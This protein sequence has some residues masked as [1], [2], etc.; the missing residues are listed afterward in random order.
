MKGL[1]HSF[2]LLLSLLFFKGRG[3]GDNEVLFIEISY[4]TIKIVYKNNNQSYKSQDGR[5]VQVHSG[6]VCLAASVVYVGNA[7]CE[8]GRCLVVSAKGWTPPH[9]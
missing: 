7:V 1:R 2:N 6:R 5:Y 9:H 4:Q 8:R 3:R